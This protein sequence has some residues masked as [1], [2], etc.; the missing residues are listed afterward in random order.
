MNKYKILII[1]MSPYP[2]T[3]NFREIKKRRQKIW[4]NSYDEDTR[5]KGARIIITP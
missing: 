5:R 4:N 3:G 2:V 1:I